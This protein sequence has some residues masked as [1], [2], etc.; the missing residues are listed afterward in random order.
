M[1]LTRGVGVGRLEWEV[2]GVGEGLGAEV[3]DHLV[4]G[5]KC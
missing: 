3:V 2:Q 1:C 5:A 4:G